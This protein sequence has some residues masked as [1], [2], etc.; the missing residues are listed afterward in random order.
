VH[1]EG[2]EAR[3]GAGLVALQDSL[4]LWGGRGGKEMTPLPSTVHLF[5]LS[6]RKW[7]QA[8][9]N[10][11]ETEP[12]ERSYHTLVSD[13]VRLPLLGMMQIDFQD[14]THSLPS[15]CMQAVRPKVDQ[16]PCCLLKTVNGLLYPMPPNQLE[17]ELLWP[18]SLIQ[19]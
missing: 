7:S 14:M 15:T 5:D 2:P 9:V 18:Y 16:L 6:N 13:G 10:S 3:V 19:D 1:R 4:L 17:V 12:Q 8:T 11:K